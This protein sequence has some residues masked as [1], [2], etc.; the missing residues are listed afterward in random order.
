MA[1]TED[2]LSALR[3]EFEQMTES[4]QS[5]NDV[6]GSLN[7]TQTKQN[8][9]TKN[10]IKATDDLTE[11]FENAG[12]GAE[13]LAKAFR[14]SKKIED[15]KK[16]ILINSAKAL[17][18]F[19]SATLSTE[20][21][22][23]KY[24]GSLTTAIDAATGAALLFAMRMGPD[25]VVVTAILGFASLLKSL[26]SGSLEMSDSSLKAK[27]EL[28]KLG[29][30]GEFSADRFRVLARN[31]EISSKEL[32]TLIKPIRNMGPALMALSST[33]GKGMTDF[34]DIVS[35][36]DDNERMR[37]RRLGLE[38]NELVESMGDYIKLQ[39]ASGMQLSLRGKSEEQ[40]RKS[41]TQYVQNLLELSALTGKDI[42]T[43]KREQQDAV[44]AENL[45][46]RLYRLQQEGLEAQ[47]ENTKTLI[48]QTENL[49]PGMT[50]GL[51]EFIASGF[52][53]VGDE[54][55]KLLVQMGPEFLSYVRESLESGLDNSDQIIQRY[56][57]EMGTRMMGPLGEI[58]TMSKDVM[59]L[60]F[61]DARSLQQ[62]IAAT[63]ETIEETRNRLRSIIDKM[64]DDENNKIE[65]ARAL[66]D[67]T[68]RVNKL[69]NDRMNELVQGPVL[70][71]LSFLQRGATKAAESLFKMVE[72]LP[73]IGGR[74][75][76][77]INKDIKDQNKLIEE[78]NNRLKELEITPAGIMSGVQTY[79]EKRK[80]ETAEFNKANLVIEL[81]QEG[82][83][84]DTPTLLASIDQI[85]KG[86]P[87]LGIPRAESLAAYELTSNLKTLLSAIPEN[88][89]DNDDVDQRIMSAQSMIT[90]LTGLAK[91]G[92][93]SGPKTGYPVNLHGTELVQPLD[94]N[95]IL[96]KLAT[97]NESIISRSLGQT[98]IQPND[99]TTVK[100]GK[101][102]ESLDT[103]SREITKSL[104][105][106]S[107]TPN[108]SIINEP[109]T[110]INNSI[111]NLSREITS[112]LDNITI[113]NEPNTEINNSI[114]ALSREIT[115]S[116]DNIS[117][118]PNISIIN[119]PNTEVASSIVSLTREITSSLDNITI[120]NEPNTEIN[121]SIDALSREITSSL[122]NISLTPNIS[123][124][125]EPNTE[126]NNS[127]DNLSREIT[128][129]LDNITIINEPNTE[130]NNSIDALSREI[131]SSLNNISLTPNI[132]IINE[133]NTEVASSIVS[134]TREI[135]SSL[136]NITII[137]EPNTE[138]NN[139]ID[140]LSREITKSLDN[141]SLTPNISI[142]NEPNTEINNS[143]DNLSR[144]IT[145]SLN[146]TNTIS[147]SSN[148]ISRS[149]SV[150]LARVPDS[151]ENIADSIHN[152]SNGLITLQEEN[153]R[154]Q[155]QAG[156]LTPI[157]EDTVTENT[158]KQLVILETVSHQLSNMIS[159]LEESNDIQTQMMRYNMT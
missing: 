157:I 92:I 7:T 28:V 27:D 147:D 125:N 62:V 150:S 51:R 91:G 93:A 83:E 124:I 25:G 131:T 133:P 96:A 100:L 10:T 82:G 97:T 34:V 68:D 114:D 101:A 142:I 151:L 107:L 36:L 9:T 129:S 113:I 118:T 127:I 14:E 37:F 58:A 110:E 106:I 109:N 49:A 73:F 115:K 6:L 18:S 54:S 145:S 116:L 149:I 130:I 128:S 141:I 139:S 44:M 59:T 48:S 138:I 87:D 99:I 17:D 46:I 153:A 26:V 140:A 77:G 53:I 79:L 154:K 120:I 19:I 32:E 126:I 76:Y 56:R 1:L 146:N 112:S 2:Q 137:N 38:Y 70:S 132:S 158:K 63:G 4:L 60:F 22:L 52:N 78:T 88:H 143:I 74:T 80:L 108:I 33:A 156:Q 90:E 13:N 119:E 35:T 148:E 29:G 21:S 84:V 15:T 50:A 16:N 121:N 122:N 155:E 42:D 135:T 86:H 104:D 81:L 89:K 102:T 39:Y 98:T 103:L 64:A 31:A 8:K 136:D 23:S 159:K 94:P 41:S 85:L 117:L 20:K 144:E 12:K 43:I 40:I 5:L 65:Q 72:N 105:N 67:V 47:A 71:A 61:T 134:L 24:S 95:S 152:I 123:I 111:D 57:D 11:E 75:E 66:S 55:S 69:L 30:A 3:D 45:Q